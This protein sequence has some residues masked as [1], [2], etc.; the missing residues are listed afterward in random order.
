MPFTLIRN[1]ITKMP[2]DAI[3]NAANSQL[4]PGGGVCGAIFAAANYDKLNRA[5]RKIGRCPV[6]QAVITKSF[7][8]P[9]KYVIHAVGPIWHGGHQNEPEL[10]RSCYIQSLH[11]AKQHGCRSISFPLISSG[12]YGYP[13]EEALRI[14]TDAI[15][16]FLKG[17]EMEVAL[18]LFDRSAVVLGQSQFSGIR[19][20]IDDHYVD[21]R[22]E[23]RRWQTESIALQRQEREQEKQFA[24]AAAQDSM[25]SAALG[26]KR[27]LRDLMEH[28]DDSFSKM[29]LRLIDEK[30]MTDVEVYKR[31]NLDRKLFSKIRKDSYK[32]S[33]QTAIALA[34]ALRLNLDETTD[35][36]GRAGYALSHSSKFDVIIEYCI[37]NQ[38]YDIYEIN[39][40]LFAFDQKLLG[41]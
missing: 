1:D 22:R 2:T 14:A 19:A 27:S 38:V 41:A 35:L 8:L 29:L 6:G 18:V 39:E 23:D 28:L 11:L 7:G 32:P 10:L 34:I 3:V 17:N 33:K 36:L 9:A 15:R 21:A 13:K 16:E 31:A 25:P 26:P 24:P 5:C 20:Y 30:G 37:D 12:I 4:M 40:A